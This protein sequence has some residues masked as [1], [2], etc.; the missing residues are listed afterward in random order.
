MIKV[1]KIVITKIMTICVLSSGL[2][3]SPLLCT[4]KERVEILLA[5]W[6]QGWKKNLLFIKKNL[7]FLVISTYIRVYGNVFKMYVLLSY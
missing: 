2:S 4:C 3:L 1:T 7:D 5:V 6:G